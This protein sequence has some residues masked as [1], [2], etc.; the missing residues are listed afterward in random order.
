MCW[1]LVFMFYLLFFFFKQKT[2]YEMRISDWSSD[3]CS[4][5]LVRLAATTGF[6]AK[7]LAPHL[8]A[9]LQAYPEIDLE[10]YLTEDRI[11]IVADGF[12][13][14]V[15]IGAGA[16]SSLRM[17]RLFSYSLPLIAAPSLLDR[18]GVPPPP[19]DHPR[20]RYRKSVWWGKRC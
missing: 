10:L 15:Q 1:L 9:F 12:D 7:A 2:A 18:L 3:V 17:S 4:S 8:P 20:H 11:D 14:A 13:A 19:H 5:D 16:D 6:G